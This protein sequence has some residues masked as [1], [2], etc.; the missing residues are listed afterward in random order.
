MKLTFLFLEIICQ[1]SINSFSLIIAKEFDD[2]RDADDCVYD[3]NG[4]ELL[5]ER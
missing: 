3:L 5:G 4:R 2:S 1:P